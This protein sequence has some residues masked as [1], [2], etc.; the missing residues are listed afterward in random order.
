MNEKILPLLVCP[1]CKGELE[2]KSKDNELLCHHD[3]LA[4]PIRK[5]I[6]I[7]LESDARKLT[8]SE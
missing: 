8:A 5:S 6:P 1:V 2:F 3:K 7:L 4:F